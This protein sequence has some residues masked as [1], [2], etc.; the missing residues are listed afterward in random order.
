MLCFSPLLTRALNRVGFRHLNCHIINIFLYRGQV[1]LIVF[2][3]G[4]IFLMRNQARNNTCVC[5][6]STFL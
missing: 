2:M 3:S 5:K 4:A 1:S 6:F